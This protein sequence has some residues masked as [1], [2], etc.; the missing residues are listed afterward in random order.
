MSHLAAGALAAEFNDPRKA[1]AELRAAM[2]AAAEPEDADEARALLAAMYARAGQD[3]HALA[4]IDRIAPQP[5]GP[6]QDDALRDARAR[7]AT[8]AQFPE[9]TVAA[10]GMSRLRYSRKGDKLSAPLTVNGKPAQFALDT[11]A[12]ISVVSESEARALAMDLRGERFDM[13]DAGGQ[14]L[15]CHSAVA[16]ELAMGKFQLRNVAFCALP[17]DQPG[18]TDVPTMERGLIGLPVLLAFGTMSWTG[19]GVLEIGAPAA[20]RDL[21]KSNLCLDG[22]SPV[23][24][25][26]VGGHRLRLTLDTGNP[27]TF[28]FREFGDDFPEAVKGAAAAEAHELQGLGESVMVE[29]RTL[30]RLDLR[31]GGQAVSLESV[32]MLMQ[33]AATCLGCSGNAG[34][35]LFIGARRV[36]LDFQAMRVTLEILT[37]RRGD[38][39]KD[40]EGGLRFSAA[41]RLRVKRGDRMTSLGGRVALVTGGSRGIGRAIALAFGHAGA[42]VAVNYR[43]R[44]ADAAGGGGADP[45]AGWPRDGCGRGCEQ[46]G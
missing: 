30:P 16:A 24:E 21:A 13:T 19:D 26:V 2:R 42:Q 37:R 35:N 43:E 28:L 29:S 18:F 6:E 1:E 34:L 39:E 15:P 5:A 11:G 40:E 25:A 46:G 10:R 4:E 17:D 38:A 12:A 27:E 23:L 9:L 3:K 31:V 44:A 22:A 20:R 36:T 14:R 32:P 41:P 8:I 7:V 33:P 45:G